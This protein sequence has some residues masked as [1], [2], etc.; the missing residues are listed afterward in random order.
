MDW[1]GKKL[2]PGLIDPK[3]DSAFSK[4]THEW[5]MNKINQCPKQI[6][7]LIS[8]SVLSV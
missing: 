4:K 1:S 2:E 8:E 6:L 3:M 7:L 5:T